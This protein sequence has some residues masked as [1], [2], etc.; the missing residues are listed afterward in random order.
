M[1]LRRKRIK[2]RK[3]KRKE[4]RKSQEKE[5]FVKKIDKMIA[6][7]RRKSKKKVEKVKK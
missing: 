7:V 5:C 2:E 3:K 6:H 4:T 1:E